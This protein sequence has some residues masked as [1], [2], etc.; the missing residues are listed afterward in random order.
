MLFHVVNFWS[1]LN[2]RPEFAP[3]DYD[4]HR[5]AFQGGG[6]KV[7]L[8][9]VENVRELEEQVRLD[10]SFGI[11]HVGKAERVDGGAFSR[12]EA[13]ELMCALYSFL[14]F[15]RGMWS[16]PILWVGQNA[17]GEHV[18]QEWSV[19]RASAGCNVLTW[20]PEHEPECLARVFPGFMSLWQAPDTREILEV[21]IHW[22]VEANL[23]AGAAEGAIILAQAGLE[24]LAYYILTNRGLSGGTTAAARLRCLF[25]EFG[26]PVAVGPARYR[27]PTLPELATAQTW[28]D[29]PH[30]L[31]RLRN[32]LVHPDQQNI[33][34]LQNFPHQAR[35][36]V[37][38]LCL[39]FYEMVLLSVVRL[40][41]AVH[42]SAN[43]G[44]F[45]A[46]R[47]N[48]VTAPVCSGQSPR[49]FFAA[50]ERR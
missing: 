41:G 11:T 35:R 34:R 48:A 33:Q 27:V 16:P 22:Y 44:V 17:S 32:C 26:L 36:E 8:Q 29:A 14:S 4:V 43:S 23:G 38:T 7:T 10:S 28:A 15:A 1:F 45:W 6:W 12:A 5:V 46:N 13:S 39:W 19:D 2:P 40:H 24:R 9:G 18:W 30:G 50:F 42:E 20:F 25:T 3:S 47:T 37:L 21:A 31:V 49:R